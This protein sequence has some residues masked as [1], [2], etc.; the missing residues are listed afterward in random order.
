MKRFKYTFLWAAFVGLVIS[1]CNKESAGTDATIEF[2]SPFENDTISFGEELHIEGKI[3]GNGL[4]DGYTF[5]MMNTNA[6]TYIIPEKTVSEHKEAYVFHEH[7]HNNVNDTA[8]VVIE[9]NV[10][11]SQDGALKTKKVTVVCLPL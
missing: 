6:G 10:R 9:V 4:L 8:S 2:I 7:W 5:S 11:T 1:S 3:E